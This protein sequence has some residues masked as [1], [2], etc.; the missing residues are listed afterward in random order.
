MKTKR[1]WWGVS[2]LLVLLLAVT[3]L[4]RLAWGQGDPGFVKVAS[5]PFATGTVNFTT[6]SPLVAGGTY[7]LEITASNVAGES[8]ATVL[9]TAVEPT[10][11]THTTGTITGVTAGTGGGTPTTLNIYLQQVT[12]P[13]PPGATGFTLN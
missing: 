13:N 9:G 5:V 10:T 2:S 4:W 11:G 1:S 3:G 12:A 6:T 7:V 8:K